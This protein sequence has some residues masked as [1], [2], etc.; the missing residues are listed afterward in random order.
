MENL[1][2][3]SFKN[4]IFYLKKTY[5]FIYLMF[6]YILILLL[7]N[8]II[9]KC[10]NYKSPANIHTP[11]I[12]KKIHIQSIFNNIGEINLFK[13]SDHHYEILP[14]LN[15]NFG[16]MKYDYR[17]YIFKKVHIKLPSE[18]SINGRKYPME[19][20]LQG[21]GRYNKQITFSIFFT[22]SFYAKRN[23]IQDW[24]FGYYMKK[25]DY[26][27]RG[28]LFN[29]KYKR[30]GNFNVKNFFDF[31]NHFIHYEG[32]STF[33]PCTKH[34]KWFI[35]NKAIKIKTSLFSG[36]PKNNNYYKSK[37]Y[38]RTFYNL[39]LIQ[40]KDK[41]IPDPI[42]EDQYRPNPKKK[43]NKPFKKN[44]NKTNQNNSTLSPIKKPI[45]NIV[46]LKNI[47]P[48]NRDKDKIIKPIKNTNNNIVPLKYNK[49]INRDKNVNI[50]PV[51]NNGNLQNQNN[52][53]NNN[54]TQNTPINNNNQKTVNNS[55]NNNGQTNPTNNNRNNPQN[56]PQNKINNG[57]IN[58]Q[59]KNNQNITRNNQN[60]PQ[61]NNRNN[62]QNFITNN[63]SSNNSSNNL[64][65][66][67]NNFPQN[68]NKNIPTSNNIGN[69]I[70]TPN[71]N[72]IPNN[73]NAPTSTLPTNNNLNNNL[74]PTNNQNS[75]NRRNQNTNN[76]N[77]T[78]INLN[79]N[80][81]GNNQ[82]KNPNNNQKNYNPSNSN[83]NLRNNQNNPRNN[84][85]IPNN[86]NNPIPKNS[87]NNNPRNNNPNNN[88]PNNIPSNNN[89]NN[90]NPTIN[91]PN[92]DNPNSNNPRNNN[93]RK[94]NPRNN[95]PNN[96]NNPNINNPNNNN[97]NNNNPRN[98]NP[99]N[100]NPNN[101]SSSTNPFPLKTS[102]DN[103]DPGC[104]DYFLYKDIL[105]KNQKI[106][107]NCL[108]PKS[109]EITD[110]KIDKTFIINNIYKNSKKSYEIYCYLKIEKC[111]KVNK[112]IPLLLEPI[113]SNEIKNE[114][115]FPKRLT[116]D[117]KIPIDCIPG[118][119]KISKKMK[120]LYFDIDLKY[121][122]NLEK[123]SVFCFSKSEFK[124]ENRRVFIP[125]YIRND[126][127]F[128]FGQNNNKKIPVYLNIDE[129]PKNISFE[130]SILPTTKL[131][132]IKSLLNSKPYLITDLSKNISNPKELLKNLMQNFFKEKDNEKFFENLRQKFLK[133][134]NEFLENLRVLNNKEK[135]VDETEM[136]KKL[137][138]LDINYNKDLQKNDI[139]KFPLGN[140]YDKDNILKIINSKKKTKDSNI[141]EDD[142]L[143]LV[144]NSD[145]QNNLDEDD[146]NNFDDEDYKNNLDDDDKNNLDDNNKD[147]YNDDD[148]NNY[149]DVIDPLINIDNID[150]I[151]NADNMFNSDNYND[152]EL[153]KAEL[154][155]NEIIKDY[156][157]YNI[158]EGDEVDDEYGIKEGDEV[159]EW[160]EDGNPFF[161]PNLQL[162][163]KIKN[164]FIVDLLDNLTFNKISGLRNLGQKNTLLSRKDL[165]LEEKQK[166]QKNIIINLVFNKMFNIFYKEK[167]IYKNIPCEEKV[168]IKKEIQ[169][170]IDSGENIENC[171]EYSCKKFKEIK[172]N[173][174][175]EDCVEDGDDK[176]VVVLNSRN[177]N[178]EKRKCKK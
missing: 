76:N 110:N 151:I 24:G 93:P 50:Q 45:N 121:N 152:L 165:N 35:Y 57:Q 33:S 112:Y 23:P 3:K 109:Q 41:I 54:S 97:P 74:N 174:F 142:I 176:L 18:H 47:K 81:P 149:D 51:V 48:L 163:Q 89:L 100:N 2:K 65:P 80:N 44:Y 127:N 39:F 38:V 14:P 37:D 69:N 105:E 155:N 154:D 16:S 8:I 167:I 31:K 125:I 136:K 32:E 26:I 134:K 4:F 161:N 9:S 164:N 19:F 138:L 171:L 84:N 36:F 168:C 61:N 107:K 126:V 96:I 172:D 59:N 111:E 141:K 129:K 117:Y 135:I 95:N 169:V 6:K 21:M 119:K 77:D 156:D 128:E 71:N 102:N 113:S 146:K 160:D 10:S 56:I 153:K 98:N 13:L 157:E 108:L 88:N 15:K 86:N 72:N 159:D 144:K 132:D 25:I 133:E 29:K 68:N 22:K 17:N 91:N 99:N 85:N 43:Y 20:Q 40:K 173:N 49:P 145:Q 175:D 82:S 140:N 131:F 124:F 166:I 42:E 64:N 66:Q 103:S 11:K 62:P 114:I 53:L 137:E 75:N 30:K 143:D 34:N 5:L 1:K 104:P 12:R 58:P 67:K 120:I 148:K 118:W 94:N 122:V 63:P 28:G 52:G 139:K 70:N 158:K 162:N 79:K 83:N 116:N 90:N 130:D 46:P 92:N 170:D 101:S 106:P 87:N 177:N 73:N 27:E 150:D 7:S 78:R 123:F 178:T 55:P 60:N 147:N 115:F